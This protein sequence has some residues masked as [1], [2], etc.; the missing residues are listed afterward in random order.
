M[1]R[2]IATIVLLCLGSVQLYGTEPSVSVTVTGASK[3]TEERPY[4]STVAPFAFEAN[5]SDPRITSNDID[6]FTYAKNSYKDEP[7]TQNV[8]VS[9]Q[10]LANDNFVDCPFILFETG[11]SGGQDTTSLHLEVVVPFPDA[12]RRERIEQAFSKTKRGDFVPKA[13]RTAIFDMWEQIE[14]MPGEYRVVVSYDTGMHKVSSEPVPFTITD[15]G[16]LYLKILND[17]RND[18]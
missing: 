10:R 11:K 2:L 6:L 8:F 15:K 16:N 13:E 17:I 4:G 12:V 1:P 5:I 9:V 14:S 3:P 7:R 18:G